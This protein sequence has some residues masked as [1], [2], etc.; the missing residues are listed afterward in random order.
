[1]SPNFKHKELFLDLTFSE[2]VNKRFSVYWIYGV[3]SRYNTHHFR[4]MK[5]LRVSKQQNFKHRVLPFLDQNQNIQQLA[6][7]SPYSAK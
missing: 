7:E 4:L 6:G 2:S 1:M 3:R 5:N